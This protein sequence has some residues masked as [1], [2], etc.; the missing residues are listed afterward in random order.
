M[1]TTA[2][3]NL[4]GGTAKTVT[5]INLAA[6]LA[7]DYAQRVLLVDA[8]SQANLTE[9][10]TEGLP[11]GISLGGF[12]D[13]LRGTE[14]FPMPTKMQNVKILAADATLME[15]DVTAAT[16]GLAHPMALADFLDTVEDR[17]DWCVIDCPPAFSAGALAA[18]AA[19]DEV[20]IPM[21]L[22]AFGIRGMAN[23]MEQIMNMRRVNAD[24]EVAGVLPTMVYPDGT[25][26]NQLIALR[27]GM[28]MEGIRTFHQV[29]RSAKVDETTF[30]QTPLIVLSPKGKATHDYKVF[31]HNL[32][33]ICEGQEGSDDDGI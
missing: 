18:L 21:K 26:K 1:R 32:I 8:D 20:V 31:V 28:Q 4:K 13:L 5:A 6:I 24:L 27:L 2:I 9:F 16:S 33:E 23:L 25:Q 30:S 19:A 11:D 12:S 17:F 22:D 29:R 14:A 7:R 10:V 15:L 3:M